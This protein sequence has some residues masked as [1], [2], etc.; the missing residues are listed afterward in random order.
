MIHIRVQGRTPL[1]TVLNLLSV[2]N[3]REFI[4]ERSDYLFPKE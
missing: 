3:V 1:N 4:G 2:T